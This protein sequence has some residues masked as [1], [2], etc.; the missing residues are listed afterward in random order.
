MAASV[1]A[2]YLKEFGSPTD[3]KN[4]WILKGA[5]SSN[6]SDRARALQAAKDNLSTMPAEDTERLYRRL[7]VIKTELANSLPYATEIRHHLTA[8]AIIKHLR[9]KFGNGATLRILA[10]QNPEFTKICHGGTIE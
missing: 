5:G 3:V 7:E 9:P 10:L 4:P 2:N 6:E 8:Y 1:L